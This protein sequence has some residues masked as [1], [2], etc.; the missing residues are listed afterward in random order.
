[1]KARLVPV[2]FKSGRDAGFNTQVERLRNLLAEEAEILEPVALGSPL[3]DAE[4]VVFPQILGDAYR[5]VNDFKKLISR[6]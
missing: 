4:A 5:Q 2:H 3:P 1:M 6:C